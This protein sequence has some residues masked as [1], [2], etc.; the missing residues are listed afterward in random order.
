MSA[1]NAVA[2][3]LP[4]LEGAKTRA[5]SSQQGARRQGIHDDGASGFSEA[6]SELGN[7]GSAKEGLAAPREDTEGGERRPLRPLQATRFWNTARWASPERV[8]AGDDLHSSQVEET[9]TQ[10]AKEPLGGVRAARPVKETGGPWAAD[11]SGSA[12]GIVGGAPDLIGTA[13]GPGTET[14]RTAEGVFDAQAAE[15]SSATARQLRQQGGP[16]SGALRAPSLSSPEAG[17]LE[18]EAKLSVVR[19]EVHFAPTAPIAVGLPSDWA[20]LALPQAKAAAS[21]SV[22]LPDGSAQKSDD[23]SGDSGPVS[24]RLKGQNRPPR[25]Q[26]VLPSANVTAGPTGSVTARSPGGDAQTLAKADASTALD[27]SAPSGRQ[28]L[29]ST[30]A[31][32]PASAGQQIA[33]RLA[34]ELPSD[35]SAGPAR[36]QAGLSAHKPP[37][38]P[39]LRVLEIQLEPAE[40]GTVSVRMS[41]R[42]NALEVHLAADRADTA[43]LVQQDRDALSDRL[44]AAGYA[45]DALVIQAKETDRAGAAPPAGTGQPG[46]GPFAHAQSGGSGAGGDPAGSDRPGAETGGRFSEGHIHD[47]GEERHDGSAARGLYV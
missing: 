23:G 22:P 6:L 43:R 15:A 26:R 32:M 3:L 17:A 4:G 44:Q 1:T 18:V 31:G 19:Q 33:D 25:G 39:V 46:V 16:H 27:A 21:G 29:P 41:L 40:L 5:L 13:A 37:A 35:S 10:S 28:D 38:G 24:D 34:S 20:P 36:S 8:G 12:Q 14:P 2:D 30:S 47:A 9:H 11:P 42:G 7:A 45:V